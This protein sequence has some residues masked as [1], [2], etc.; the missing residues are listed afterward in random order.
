MFKIAE[1]ETSFAS[2]VYFD[3]LRKYVID[4]YLA[5]RVLSLKY[6]GPF[7]ILAEVKHNLKIHQDIPI[8]LRS[9]LLNTDTQKQLTFL[10]C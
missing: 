9:V 1:K 8:H 7:Y 6:C 5:H 2:E 4:K 10:I 3:E